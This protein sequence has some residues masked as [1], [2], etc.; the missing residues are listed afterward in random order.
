MVDVSSTELREQ[1]ASGTGEN[2]LPP[3]VYGYILR[4]DLY[5]TRADL[6][7]PDA[8]CSCGRWL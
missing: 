7:Q 4:R 1:L 8:C 5:G 2:L 3:A 6:K